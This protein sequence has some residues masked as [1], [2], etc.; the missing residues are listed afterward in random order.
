VS[1][2]ALL[3]QV[4]QLLAVISHGV[5]IG[6]LNRGSLPRKRIRGS[7]FTAWLRGIARARSRI[8]ERSRQFGMMVAVP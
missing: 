6:H 7:G 4:E 3:Q 1:H 8:S 5:S 2:L